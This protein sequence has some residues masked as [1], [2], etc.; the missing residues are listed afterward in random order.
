[1]DSRSPMRIAVESLAEARAA[2]GSGDLAR[3]LDLVDDGLAALGPHYQRSGL[4]D[5]S[6]LKLTLAAVRRRQGDAAGAFAAME[7]VLEDRIAAY[8]GRSGDAS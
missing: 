8:E 4:I 7:R 3:A 1:M 6:G 5:D 2:A